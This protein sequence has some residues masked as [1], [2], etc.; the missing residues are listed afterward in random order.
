MYRFR[1]HPDWCWTDGYVENVA[2]AVA[3]ATTHAAAGNHVYNIGEAYTPTIA[4]RLASMPPSTIE[5]DLDSEFNFGQNIAYD[6]GRIEVNW[7][8]ARPFRKRKLFSQPCGSSPNDYCLK[9][10]IPRSIF[11]ARGYARG[12]IPARA[13]KENYS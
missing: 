8:I 9:P 3:L 4:E 10:R 12:I 7:A 5:P 13:H 2:G 11:N 6:T 1:H